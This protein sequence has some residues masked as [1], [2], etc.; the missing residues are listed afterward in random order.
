MN[1][2]E[3]LDRL[4]DSLWGLPPE[5]V[6]ERLAFYGENIDDRME[7]GLSEE[8]AVAQI[9]ILDSVREQIMSEIP[10]AKLVKEKVRSK[11]SLKVWEI[12]LLVLGSP[13]WFP[14]LIAAAA[15]LLAVYIVLWAAVVCFYAVAL[16]LAAGVLA[17]LAG[18]AAS[19]KAGNLSA[20]VFSLG[21][22]AVCAGLGILLFF[23]CVWMTKAVLKMTGKMIMGIKSVLIGKED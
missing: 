14:L 21:A 22:G 7:E 9:G 10:L 15:V 23:A 3:F 16:S 6:E 4:R 17:G 20:A 13:V 11:R 18:I 8:E 19:L 5:E 2:Q 1:K 12:V